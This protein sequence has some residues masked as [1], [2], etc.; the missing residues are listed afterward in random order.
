MRDI[1][2]RLEAA[3]AATDAAASREPLPQCDWRVLTI[4][5]RLQLLEVMDECEDAD[6]FAARLAHHPDL[7]AALDRVWAA[8]EG[9]N[10]PATA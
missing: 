2:R 9:E 4:S 8:S 6:E 3:E 5:E 1:E 7:T 10:T